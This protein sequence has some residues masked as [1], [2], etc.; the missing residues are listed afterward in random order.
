M[1]AKNRIGPRTDPCGTPEITGAV[2]DDSP[3]T[4]T[5]YVRS[6]RKAS[7]QVGASDAIVFELG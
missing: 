5:C 4:T 3:S 1:N 7:L 6:D 2:F